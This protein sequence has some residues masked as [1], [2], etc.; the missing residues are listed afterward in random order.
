[1]HRTQ[2]YLQ[3]ELYEKLRFRSRSLGV[4][5]SELVRRVLEKGVEKDPA[6]D[7]LAFFERLSPLE[8]F[9]DTEPETYVSE[10]RAGSRLLRDAGNGA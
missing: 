5:V 7:A 4:S 10:L 3:D 1:M 6:A 8:S 2:I 9:T